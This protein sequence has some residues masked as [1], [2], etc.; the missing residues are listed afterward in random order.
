MK[1]A[2]YTELVP[3]RGRKCLIRVCY[4]FGL[5]GYLVY[6]KQANEVTFKTFHDSP[7]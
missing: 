1:T 3:Q 2:V 6:S 7:L 5:H 4:L